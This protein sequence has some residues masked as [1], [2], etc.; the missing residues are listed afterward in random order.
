MSTPHAELERRVR[1]EVEALHA[2]ISEWFRG[3]LTRSD[4][5]FQDEFAARFA[6]GFVN[7]QPAGRALSRAQL[8]SAIE[9]GHGA[10]PAFRIAIRHCALQGVYD[11]GRLVLA[12]YTE[13][14]QGASNTNPPDNTRVSSVLFEVPAGKGRLSWLHLHETALPS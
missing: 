7:V 3:E 1:A 8:L 2:F 12:L 13:F 6:P 11:E 10:N 4:A 9:Q 5:V 14:Q